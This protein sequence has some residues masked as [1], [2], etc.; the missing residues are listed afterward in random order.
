M[1]DERDNLIQNLHDAGCD[2]AQISDFLECA[3]TKDTEEQIRFLRTHRRTLMD[4]LHASQKKVD[5]LDFL[6]YK[7]GKDQKS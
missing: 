4:E 3:R 7:L 5:C 6:V 1:T 2:E